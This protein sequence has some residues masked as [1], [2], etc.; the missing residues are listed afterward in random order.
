M[1]LNQLYK[2]IKNEYIKKNSKSQT[3]FEK[4]LQVM[5]GGNTRTVNFHYPFLLS[6][7]KGEGSHIWD[8]DGNR[9]ID[10]V[11]NYTSMIHGHAHPKIIEAVNEV[12][13]NGTSYGALMSEQIKLSKMI[14]SRMNSIEKIRYCNSGTEAA[15][16]GIRLARAYKQKP[17][18][19]KASG[20]YHGAYDDMEGVVGKTYQDSHFIMNETLNYGIPNEVSQHIFQV[21]YNNLKETE[22]VLQK[23]HHQIA[24]IIIEPMLGAG[25]VI[26]PEEGYLSG[27]R[28]LA[29]E[30]DVLLIF[31]EVQTF[32]FSEGGAQEK[33]NVEADLTLLGKIIGGGFPIGALGGKEHIMSLFDQTKQKDNLLK[34][35]GTYNGNRIS[36]AAGAVTLDMLDKSQIDKMDLLSEKLQQGIIEIINKYALPACVTRE[37]SILNFHFVK[38]IPK[39]FEETKTTLENGL[40]IVHLD[41]INH[42]VFTVPRGMMN[43]ST[44]I[45]EEQISE[46]I[47]AFD[48]VLFKISKVL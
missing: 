33:Y 29:D 11:N 38:E 43:L 4:A 24:A 9:Y 25:G 1:G 28:D 42:G 7:E 18:I 10:L 45:T 27:L 20:G 14:K 31:D 2:S 32:R 34:Q 46:V 17:G 47:K 5:P 44:A 35:N 36:L 48:E 12:M 16:F 40:N 21:P 23:F 3:Q 8:V 13:Q 37:G 22:K 15:L 19:L 6:I 39:N 26:A 30:F 41:L